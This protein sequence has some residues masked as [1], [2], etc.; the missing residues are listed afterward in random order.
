MR[1]PP[2]APEARGHER[3]Q[4]KLPAQLCGSQALRLQV[5]QLGAIVAALRDDAQQE[6][7]QREHERGHRGRLEHRHRRARN[8]VG[9]Q[10]P[11]QAGP[12]CDVENRERRRG[13]SSVGCGARP[14]QPE[15][16]R[17]ARAWGRRVQRGHKGGPV[18][19]HEVGRLER[20]RPRESP[21]DPGNAKDQ[22]LAGDVDP[23][24]AVAPGELGHARRDDSR[25]A[26]T[27][28]GLPRAQVGVDL[29][30]ERQP[31]P[32]A[33][34]ANQAPDPGRAD[35]V[36]V[37]GH[38][39]RAARCDRS[40]RPKRDGAGRRSPRVGAPLLQL[41]RRLEAEGNELA[42]A[43]LRRDRSSED[44]RPRVERAAEP[45]RHERAVAGA[46]RRDHADLG[47][48]HAD[49]QRQS[50]GR[51]RKDGAAEWLRPDVDPARELRERGR[52]EVA[53]PAVDPRQSLRAETKRRRCRSRP[54]RPGCSRSAGSPARRE[55][56]AG[57]TRARPA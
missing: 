2:S 28:G 47:A 17:E 5:E 44:D 51:E 50:R 18:G 15:L 11:L 49:R 23:E 26:Q 35:P 43:R 22:A 7:E 32:H 9:A 55:A 19:D 45:H 24:Q 42:P 48:E 56:P 52:R 33:V 40:G 3:A 39:H 10:L 36:A 6:P 38:L 41:R 31:E 57:A 21:G 20:G 1:I 46:D 37:V 53:S 29:V 25:N 54:P 13:K 14:A 12:R 4:A 27:V 30:G 8:R 34:S 16:G